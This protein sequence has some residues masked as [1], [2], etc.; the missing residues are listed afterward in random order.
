MR[1]TLASKQKSL[2]TFVENRL[3]EIKSH[4]GMSFK[5]V[6]TEENPADL[7]TKGKSPSELQQSIW[8]N[9]P[10]WLSAPLDKWPNYKFAETT[11]T[12]EEQQHHKVLFEAKLMA[13]ESLDLTDIKIKRFSTLLKLLRTTVWILR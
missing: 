5:Y 13:G 11:Q 9:G 10:I 4:K 2:L 6:P 8:W 12:D 7:A 3:I 1:V